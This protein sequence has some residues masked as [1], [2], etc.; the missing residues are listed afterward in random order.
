MK[1]RLRPLG[2]FLGAIIIAPFG[3]GTLIGKLG[4]VVFQRGPFGNLARQFVKPVNPNTPRQVAVRGIMQQLSQAWNTTLTNTNRTN[5]NLYAK[6][7]PMINKTGQQVFFSGRMQFIRSQFLNVS[8]NGI[9]ALSAA[10]PLTPG[11]HQAPIL[12]LTFDAATGVVELAGIDVGGAT[13]WVANFLVASPQGNQVNYF[14]GPFASTV[15]FDQ[16]MLPPATLQ[17]FGA[18][19]VGTKCFVSS[20]ILDTDTGKASTPDIF[21]VIAA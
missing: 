20:R 13:N 17:T 10:A 14:K 3:G 8:K 7:T 15:E 16:T 5:W 18:V 11:I 19:P 1:M 21:E 12:A 2:R 9:G 6:Q 4:S